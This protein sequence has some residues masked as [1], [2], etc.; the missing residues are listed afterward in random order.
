MPHVFARNH[1]IM[2]TKLSRKAIQ[3]NQI[4][5]YWRCSLVPQFPALGWKYLIGGKFRI[6]SKPDRI[7]VGRNWN[8]LRATWSGE[9]LRTDCNLSVEVSMVCALYASLNSSGVKHNQA[10]HLYTFRFA[11]SASLRPRLN[12]S[13]SESR[14]LLQFQAIT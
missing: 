5:I 8:S 3:L 6:A 4:N 9:E 12:I 14:A 2:S 7:R 13:R 1:Q 11:L 10:C